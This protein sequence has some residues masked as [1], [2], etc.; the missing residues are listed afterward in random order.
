MYQ[1]EEKIFL[2]LF[3]KSFEEI[4]VVKHKVNFKHIQSLKIRNN[5]TV[6]KINQKPQNL[7][8]VNGQFN[9]QSRQ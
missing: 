5:R 7:T 6:K 3:S 2:R 4:Y 9:S 8:G 1:Q